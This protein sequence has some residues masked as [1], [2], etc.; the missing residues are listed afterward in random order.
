V[1]PRITSVSHN[2]KLFLKKALKREELTELRR[3]SQKKTESSLSGME[4]VTAEL[5]PSEEIKEM[6]KSWETVAL[7]IH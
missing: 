1:K 6:L 2:E 4:E 7:Y 3:V 5:T